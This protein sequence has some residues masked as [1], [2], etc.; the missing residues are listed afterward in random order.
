MRIEGRR[1]WGPT[2]GAIVIM[3]LFDLFDQGLSTDTLS[4][5][6]QQ[7]RI[8]QQAQSEDTFQISWVHF[9]SNNCEKNLQ[10]FLFF[11]ENNFLLE[12]I[13]QVF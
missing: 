2:T 12:L 9:A 13:R 3:K 4:A 10:P 8:F 7:N 6:W 5:T 1:K 11:K